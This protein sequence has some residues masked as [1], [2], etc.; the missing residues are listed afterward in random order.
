VKRGI[1]VIEDDDQ[2]ARWLRI[3]LERAGYGVS[4]ACSLGEGRTL[5]ER[6]EADLVILDLLLP[7]GDGRDFCREVRASSDIPVIVVTAL[8]SRDAR[9]EGLSGGADDFITK[10]F[11]P[12]ELILR[13]EAVL[14]RSKSQVRRVI[15]CGPLTL[16]RD[17]G[18]FTLFGEPI[19]LSGIQ[20]DLMAQFM[21]HP[22]AILSRQQL[23][24]RALSTRTEIFDRAVDT[25]I[26]RLRK[27]I[28]R[29]GFEPLQTV[30]GQGYRLVWEEG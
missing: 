24:E 21:E 4:R 13:M 25:H 20:R 7:D 12:D 10:P 23:M 15:D 14:R 11:D 1:L 5:L 22:N 3:Y 2:T 16:D 18:L 30:Y 26:Q 27:L 28:H 29:E 9:L 19:R 6:G 8:S 17:R